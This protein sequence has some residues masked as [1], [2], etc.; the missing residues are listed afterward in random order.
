MK[1]K[2]GEDLVGY[3]DADCGSSADDRKPNTEFDFKASGTA[4]T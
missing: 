2:S 1:R 3:E 4:V